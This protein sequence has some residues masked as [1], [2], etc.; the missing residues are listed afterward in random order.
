MLIFSLPGLSLYHIGHGAVLMVEP[1][2]TMSLRVNNMITKA[3][4]VHLNDEDTH[5]IEEQP[6]E[7]F[8]D[9][10]VIVATSDEKTAPPAPPDFGSRY[11]VLSLIEHGGMGSVYKVRDLHLDA[12]FAIKTLNNK[13]IKDQVAQKR[14]EKEVEAATRLS[15]PSLVTVYGHGI[16]SLGTPYMVMDY[17]EGQSLDEIIKDIG[18][19]EPDRACNILLQI[20][21]GLQFA[22]S[23]GIVHRD[24]KPTNVL[25]TKGETFE[26]AKLVDFGIAMVLPSESRETRD[27]TQ[28]GEVFGSPHYMSPEQC[29]GFMIDN[30]SDVYAFGCM[31]YETLTGRPTFSGSTPVQLIIDHINTDPKPFPRSIHISNPIS[32]IAFNWVSRILDGTGNTTTV[33]RFP[34]A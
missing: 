3:T 31:M 10:P 21:E 14:F 16:T 7:S 24:I 19:L 34:H 5:S 11:E 9:Q 1:S 13:L 18:A 26:T 33:A 4:S 32:R 17:V 28:T 20:A 12:V 22:H 2:Q 23:Q 30:R 8:E 6:T 15:H 29:L 27:L 25:I